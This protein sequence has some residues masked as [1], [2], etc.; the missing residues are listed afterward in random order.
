MWV[1]WLVAV[2]VWVGGFWLAYRVAVGSGRWAV[3]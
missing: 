2:V 1:K 3:R